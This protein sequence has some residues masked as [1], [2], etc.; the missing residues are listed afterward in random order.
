[1]YA[2]T[3]QNNTYR[4]EKEWSMETNPE[5]IQMWDLAEKDIK[6][7]NITVPCVQKV[8]QR[9]IINQPWTSEDKSGM[10]NTVYE[11]NSRKGM[12]EEK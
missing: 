2:D 12:R 7:E 3:E 10:K 6:T 4:E 5:L 8:I 1:M 9:C 11:I